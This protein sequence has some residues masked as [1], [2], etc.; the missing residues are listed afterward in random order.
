MAVKLSGRPTGVSDELKRQ[1]SEL[2]CIFIHMP[3]CAG[4]AVQQGLF[5]KIVFGHQTI[6][7]YQIALPRAVYRDAWKFTVTRNPWERILSAWRFMKAGGFHAHDAEYF[8][9]NLRQYT[10]FDHFVNDWLVHQDFNECGC[11]HFKPQLHY[12]RNFKGEI[13]M[14][15]IVKLSDLECEYSH[16]RARLGGG[17]L[18]VRNKT[19][20]EDADWH[21][22]YDNNETF[23]NISKIYAEDIKE[24]GYSRMQGTGIE[25]GASFN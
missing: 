19:R 25:A 9:E 24:L 10:T 8:K 23:E 17:E 22:F 7:Q 4:N 15:H 5:G 12:I 21:G 16:L 13:A 3:K 18:A 6:R 2:K 14:D 11:V 1:I 20:G